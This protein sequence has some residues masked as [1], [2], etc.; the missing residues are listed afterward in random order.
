MCFCQSCQKAHR[1]H[2]NGEPQVIRAHK[3]TCFKELSQ[4]SPN[5]RSRS[6]PQVYR[7]LHGRSA[8]LNPRVSERSPLYGLLCAAVTLEGDLLALETRA[9]TTATTKSSAATSTTAATSST[10]VP[11]TTAAT[12]ATTTEPTTAA[13]E[14]TTTT[15]V[16]TGLGVVETDRTALQI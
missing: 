4:S 3:P 5:S 14:T 12:S 16:V 8:L 6:S 10:K 9:P 7:L 2:E 1:A 13:A 11:T 15:V